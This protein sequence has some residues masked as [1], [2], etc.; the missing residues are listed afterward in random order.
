ME[1]FDIGSKTVDCKKCRKV[2]IE[3]EAY[4]APGGGFLCKGCYRRLQYK[5]VAIGL[6]L[7]VLG[8]VSALAMLAF[9]FFRNWPPAN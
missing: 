7:A 9:V 2:S 3:I 5:C 8:T 4:N 1:R 6:T